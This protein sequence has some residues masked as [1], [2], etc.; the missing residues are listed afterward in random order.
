MAV[1]T[2]HV[3]YTAHIDTWKKCRD[4]SSGQEAVHA[5]GDVYLPRLGGQDPDDYEAYKK[6]AGF[7]NATGRTV[8]GLSGMVFRKQP[9][10]ENPEGLAEF[11]ED[12]DQAGMSF[13]GLAEQTLEEVLK[14]GRYGVLVD[15]P[16][17]EGEQLT[18]A[19]AQARGLRPFIKTYRAESIID[20]RVDQVENRATL[21]QVRLLETVEEPADE[22]ADDLVEQIRV[23]ELTDEGYQQRVF[24][25][26]EKG[27]W[28]LH[29]LVV[30][31]MGSVPLDR[32]P[33][34]FV[35]PRDNTWSVSKPPLLDLVNVNLQHYQLNADYRHG[36]HFVALPTPYGTGLRQEDVDAGN[37]A[38][39][40]PT[41]FWASTSSES[42]FGM[43]EYQGAG[44][45]SLKEALDDLKHDMAVLGARMLEAE[46]RQVEAAETAGIHRAGEHGVLASMAMA[47]SDVM[48]KV[49]E[50][51]R[52]WMGVTGDVQVEL[53]RDYVPTPLTAQELTAL[54]SAVQ[55]GEL[56]RE[57]FFYN[58]KQGERYP[59]GWT[60]DDE[61]EAITQDDALGLLGRD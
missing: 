28:V 40:G 23:L 57:A 33:F 46:K 43:L 14:V 8:D 11:M 35:G 31:L 36:L 54:I 42:S 60:F 56:S 49:L 22:F 51:V 25:Q 34:H 19:Q 16:Q 7:L 27:Q 21:V 26:D 52:D 38:A 48:T 44:L 4:V 32:I 17:V 2:Q 53:N 24:R 50:D 59:D 41:S 20:W 6:R 12:V 55:S 5:A 45:G 1:D 10:V 15:Y 39:I 37:F 13:L 61:Q 29:E 9:S 47:I 30:P 58:L 18:Q 3:D